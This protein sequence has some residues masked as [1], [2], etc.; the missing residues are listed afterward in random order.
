MMLNKDLNAIVV[1]YIEGRGNDLER[2]KLAV[3]LLL[4]NRLWEVEKALREI[5][6]RP[7]TFVR[8]RRTKRER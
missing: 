2:S 7:T 8:R 4:T 6:E 5:A 1:D 3:A